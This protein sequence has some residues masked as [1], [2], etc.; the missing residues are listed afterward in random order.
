LFLCIANQ[1]KKISYFYELE[2]PNST[3]QKIITIPKKKT[4]T[5]SFFMVVWPE[6]GKIGSDYS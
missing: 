2:Q 6:E 3:I 1:K 5:Y 4:E